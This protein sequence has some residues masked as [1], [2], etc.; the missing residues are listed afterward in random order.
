MDYRPL[1]KQKLVELIDESKELTFGELLYSILR[2]KVLKNKPD[3]ANTSWLLEIEDSEFYTALEKA[4][5][6][7]KSGKEQ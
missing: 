1:L 7:E 4:M 6:L 5:E 2:K 3:N